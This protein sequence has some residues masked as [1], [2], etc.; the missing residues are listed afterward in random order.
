MLSHFHLYGELRFSG[1]MWRRNGLLGLC[2][3]DYDDDDE[4]SE[5]IGL[6]SATSAW[7]KATVREN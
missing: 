2:E 7:K 1:V 5:Y 6:S 3:D 4:A